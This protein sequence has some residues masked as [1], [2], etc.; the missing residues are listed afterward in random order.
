ME[1]ALITFRT[2]W[3]LEY[4]KHVLEFHGHQNRIFHFIFCGT[5]MNAETVDF[6]L[7]RC[8]V[9]ILVFQFSQSTAIN[10]ISH[11][12]A[13]AGHIKE[14]CAAANFLVRGKSDADLAVWD[15]RVG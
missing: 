12:S 2:H 3:I 10:G 14:I 11:I 1:K 9:K 4:R 6:Y 5:W 13:K 8:C 7:R 15:L